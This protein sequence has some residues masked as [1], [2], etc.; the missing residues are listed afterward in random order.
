MR[1]LLVNW[2]KMILESNPLI[3]LIGKQA[4]KYLRKPDE[5]DQWM[6]KGK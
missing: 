5:N 2:K 4:G 1:N 3:Q 6:K